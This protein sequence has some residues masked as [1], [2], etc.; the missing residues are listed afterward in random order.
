MQRVTGQ[1]AFFYDDMNQ[2]C[3]VFWLL[4]IGFALVQLFQAINCVPFAAVCGVY[5]DVMVYR[6]FEGWLECNFE[7][8]AMVGPPWNKPSW[9]HANIF[10]FSPSFFLSFIFKQSEIASDVCIGGTLIAFFQSTISVS[11]WFCSEQVS[12]CGES[13]CAA[14]NWTVTINI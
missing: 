4:I 5:R 11:C 10:F 3:R 14:W 7:R 6:A 1:F 9:D 8:I 2:M 13:V 12:L